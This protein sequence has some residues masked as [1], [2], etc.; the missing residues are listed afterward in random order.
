MEEIK[1]LSD[2]TAIIR[3]RIHWLVWP[4]LAIF[5]IA[6]AVALFLPNIFKSEAIILIEGKQVTDA[7][8]PTTVTSYA[9]QRIQ[10]ISQQVMSRSKIL[11]LVKKFNLYPEEKKK[12]STDALV[13]MVKD[14]IGITPI[15][16]EIKSPR[17]NQ[18]S[19][20]DYCVPAFF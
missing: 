6:A 14:S 1:G 2:Y 20:F 16:A 15:S 5:I 11:D 12:I 8:V 10:S 4:T 3:R 18:P 7:L 19:P 9:D 13:E 17:S